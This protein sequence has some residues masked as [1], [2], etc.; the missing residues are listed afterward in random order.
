MK[1]DKNKNLYLLSLENCMQ[2]II[3]CKTRSNNLKIGLK[4]FNW[5]GGTKLNKYARSMR[6]K[7]KLLKNRKTM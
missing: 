4:K 3:D 5:N 7:F 2:V 6:I 1:S